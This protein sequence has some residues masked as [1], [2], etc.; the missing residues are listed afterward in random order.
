MA[1]RDLRSV[2][3]E[4]MRDLY[5]CTTCARALLDRGF[6][7]SPPVDGRPL[8][9]ELGR[10]CEAHERGKLRPQ[11]TSVILA[12]ESSATDEDPVPIPIDVG[13]L[14]STPPEGIPGLSAAIT[15]APPGAVGP[16]TEIAARLLVEWSRDERI[17][18]DMMI[19][20]AVGVARRLLLRTKGR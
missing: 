1:M 19:D 11:A 2:V 17:C 12:P 9:I 14:A 3:E 5:V 15:P 6:T 10:P 20:A 4:P 18:D 16:E 13:V 8:S 7:K